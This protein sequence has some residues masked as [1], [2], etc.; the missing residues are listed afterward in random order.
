MVDLFG[1]LRRPELAEA[2]SELAYRRGAV[3]PDAGAAVEAALSAFVLVAVPDEDGE[4]LAVG[5]AAFPTLPEGAEDLP[6]ILDVEPRSVDRERVGRVA[7]KRL[8]GD[9]ARAVAAGDA[10]RIA[11]LRDITYDLEAWA[12]V[13]L[14]DLRGRL[15]EAADGTN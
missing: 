5:P 9:A 3:P 13:E 8:R 4:L 12:P 14:A 15:D 10:D 1:A 7:E 6:H 2:V 11:A